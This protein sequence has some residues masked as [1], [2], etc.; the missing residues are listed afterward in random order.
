MQQHFICDEQMINQEL[1]ADIFEA[2]EK[3]NEWKPVYEALL[4]VTKGNKIE[5]INA[6]KFLM[7]MKELI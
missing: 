4:R 5:A 1:I 3:M 6:L 2:L 7:R